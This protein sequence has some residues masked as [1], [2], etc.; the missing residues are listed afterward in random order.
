MS[1]ENV[2]GR[3]INEKKTLCGWSY[4]ADHANNHTTDRTTNG[5]MWDMRGGKWSEEKNDYVYPYV[6][7]G[8]PK[9]FVNLGRATVSWGLKYDRNDADE[10][11]LT[12]D[13]DPGDVLI[14]AG[15][16]R[17]WC[18]ACVGI[19][20][21]ADCSCN[22]NTP[23]PGDKHF[24]SDEQDRKDFPFDFCQLKVMDLRRFSEE[25]G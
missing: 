15:E 16:S 11:M 14:R 6:G 25:R 3:V 12:V 8:T 20:M 22:T 5:K 2:N 9:L 21:N 19:Y 24:V 10:N 18:S 1:F 17:S 4:D 23:Q 13:L 7:D